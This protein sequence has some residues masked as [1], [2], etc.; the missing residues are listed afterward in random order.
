MQNFAHPVPDKEGR[1]AD[2]HERWTRGAVDALACERRT[3]VWG[4]RRSYVV[5]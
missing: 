4:G 5:L 2:R 3:Q 1:L